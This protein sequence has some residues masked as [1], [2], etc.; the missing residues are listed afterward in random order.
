MDFSQE[1]L[2]DAI[3]RLVGGLLERAGV[4]RPPVNALEIAENHLGI[5]VEVVEP[6][7][8]DERGRRRP[9]SRPAG[10]GIVLSEDMSEEQ[11]QKVAADGIARAL[12]PHVLR[13]L[14]V[15]PGTENKQFA[16]HVRGLL[17]ARLLIPSR[18]LR[19]A[20]KE[21]RYDVLALKGAFSTATTEAVALRLLDLDEPCVIAIVDDGVVS[22]R[23]GNRTAAS[24]KL[25]PAEQTCLDRVMELDLPHRVRAGEWTVHGWPVSGR[26]FRRIILRAVPDEL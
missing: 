3:D 24:R 16:A 11:R 19:V 6:A 5:P 4:V 7:E 9:R 8:E 15:V 10:A 18:L 25:E 23:R 14:D 13:K 1:E 26:S 17:A 12:L 2:L 21:C 22:V 20:L